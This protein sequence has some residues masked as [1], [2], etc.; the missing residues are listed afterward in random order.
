MKIYTLVIAYNDDKEEIEYISEEIAGDAKGVL[1]E[2]GVV[3]IGDYFDED[4]LD[5]ISGCYI[6]GEA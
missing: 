5:F 2:S 3:K 1:E 6:I 4:D